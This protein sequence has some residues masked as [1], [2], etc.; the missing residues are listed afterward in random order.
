MALELNSKGGRHVG[1]PRTK[2]FS[3]YNNAS[4][5]E[6]RAVS[7]KGG[8]NLQSII[9]RYYKK[10]KNKENRNKNNLRVYLFIFEVSDTIA[11]SHEVQ[12]QFY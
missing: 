4:G 12:K 9:H 6:N 10:K 1:Q 11:T 3:Q 2:G 8:G 5:R 7:T